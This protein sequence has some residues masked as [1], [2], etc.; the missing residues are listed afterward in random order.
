MGKATV[1]IVLYALAVGAAFESRRPLLSGSPDDPVLG[2]KIVAKIAGELN[3]SEKSGAPHPD[4]KIVA[5]EREADEG[6][7]FVFRAAFQ[8]LSAALAPIGAPVG[9]LA[10]VFAPK[11]AS[12][13]PVEQPEARVSRALSV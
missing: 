10:E 11:S 6:G 4:F 1:N 13:A 7:K 5:E 8:E 2:A 3:A 12:V 9:T